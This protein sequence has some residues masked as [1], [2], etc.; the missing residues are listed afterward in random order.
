MQQLKLPTLRI[1]AFLKNPDLN[2]PSMANKGM[3]WAVLFAWAPVAMYAV[4]RDDYITAAFC[5]F[6]GWTGVLT[7]EAEKLKEYEADALDQYTLHLASKQEHAKQ[8]EMF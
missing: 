4:T 6:A 3:G 8:L 5:A 1:P 2:R 7:V